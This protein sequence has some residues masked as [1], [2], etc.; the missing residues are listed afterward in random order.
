MYLYFP[1][2]VNL[3]KV[4]LRPKNSFEV[5]QNFRQLLNTF[6]LL[7]WK[8]IDPEKYVKQQDKDC[9]DIANFIIK[10]LNVIKKD[11]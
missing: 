4:Y 3:T 5:I 1:K 7:G 8:K 9:L 10:K 11:K 2:H 6:T